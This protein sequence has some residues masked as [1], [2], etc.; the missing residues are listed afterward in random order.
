MECLSSENRGIHRRK[1][2]ESVAKEH[3]EAN[4][5]NLQHIGGEAEEGEERP[6]VTDFRGRNGFDSLRCRC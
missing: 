3:E 5:S 6:S 2:A 1:P 4:G